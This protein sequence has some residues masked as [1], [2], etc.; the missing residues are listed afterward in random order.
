M[1]IMIGVLAKNARKWS[2]ERLNS[3]TAAAAKE[4]WAGEE[5][6]KGKEKEKEGEGQ[7]R[8]RTVWREKGRRRESWMWM[9]RISN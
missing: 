8:E 9:R 4:T 1:I 3:A 7:G 6:G 2:N 5:K